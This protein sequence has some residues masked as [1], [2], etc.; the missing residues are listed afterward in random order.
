MSRRLDNFPLQ[1]FG[2]QLVKALADAGIPGAGISITVIDVAENNVTSTTNM[3]NEAE[4][5]LLEWLV[6]QR[7]TGQ[8]TYEDKAEGGSLN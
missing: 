1:V 4:T 2:D 3:V 5:N 6:L 7:L 8:Y